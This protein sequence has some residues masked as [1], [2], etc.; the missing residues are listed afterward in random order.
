MPRE[1]ICM[2]WLCHGHI[3]PYEPRAGRP[4]CNYNPLFMAP[5][6]APT[7]AVH[8]RT[9]TR[10]MWVSLRRWTVADQR[11]PLLDSDKAEIYHNK[12]T[13]SLLWY[14][15]NDVLHIRGGNQFDLI[16]TSRMIAEL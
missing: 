16:K 8:S 6:D 11:E 12:R 2:V 14:L 13:P 4:T 1:D 15:T 9:T 3:G 5:Y 10:T 7:P